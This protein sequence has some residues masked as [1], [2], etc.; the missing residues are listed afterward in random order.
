M[1]RHSFSR[2][3]FLV[4]GLSLALFLGAC[5][6]KT[7]AAAGDDISISGGVTGGL[8]DIASHDV[9]PGSVA[10]GAACT[11]DSNCQS[12]VCDGGLC[13]K[14]CNASTECA[15]GQGCFTDDNARSYCHKTTAPTGV[16]LACYMDQTCPDGLTCLGDP[17]SV[18]AVCSTSCTTN[19]DCAASMECRIDVTD[20]TGKNQICSPRRFC[21]ACVTDDECGD[22][23]VCVDMGLG[24][25]FCSKLCDPGSFECPR[26]ADCTVVTDPIAGDR[27]VCTHRSGTCDG[28]GTLCQPCADGRC[29]TTNNFECL[30]FGQS[31]ESFCTDTCTAAA[32]CGNGYKCT[33]VDATTKRCVP[34]TNRCVGKLTEQYKI[35]DIFEDY[36]ML[37]RV[38]TNGDGKLSDEAP[39][40]IKLSDFAD[41][42]VIGITISAGWCV[43]CQDETM[44]FAA[45]M[46]KYGDKAMIFQI[47]IQ[48]ANETQNPPHIDLDFSLQ[49]I[50]Q[51]NVVG[52]SGIDPNGTPNL[53]NVPGSI[54]LNILIDAKTRKILEKE[55]GASADG[56]NTFFAKHI[57]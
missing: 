41:K 30:T 53:W 17:G 32:D 21:S 39:Q 57:Q 23:G 40:L 26:Y 15:T 10:N 37:G 22:G 35:G 28:D 29:D 31:G 47:L 27:N 44:T 14:T 34:S 12:A 19:L 4:S 56:W 1:S 20:P 43:P 33:L 42:Q 7:A 11:E 54:P 49:W 36:A 6:T 25:R 18:R 8:Q 38:D 51:F 9:A 55:N 3:L 45:T 2:S 48:D 52:V 13:A 5:G 24:A 50:K 16:G 46:K